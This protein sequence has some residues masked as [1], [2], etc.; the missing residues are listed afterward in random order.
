VRVFTTI[1]PQARL[2]VRQ[3]EQGP[4]PVGAFNPIR[5]DRRVKTRRFNIGKATDILGAERLD[6]ARQ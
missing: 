5:H 3:R 6:E 1:R 4:P 2:T